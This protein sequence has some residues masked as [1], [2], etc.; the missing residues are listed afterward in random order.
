MLLFIELNSYEKMPKNPECDLQTS[1]N[2]D[3]SNYLM[4]MIE[5]TSLN[6]DKTYI[7]THFDSVKLKLIKDL[8]ENNNIEYIYC[9]NENEIKNKKINLVVSENALGFIDYDLNIEIITPKQFTKG[10]IFKVSKY[11]QLNDKIVQVYNKEDTARKISDILGTDYEDMLAH[12]SK[13][14]SIERVIFN[15]SSVNFSIFK[16]ATSFSI[17]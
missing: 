5:E 3:Y 11:K 15:L 8:L 16:L 7:V 6:K 10:K 13:K 14:S 9:D 12:V 1:N 2:I 4:H 17:C